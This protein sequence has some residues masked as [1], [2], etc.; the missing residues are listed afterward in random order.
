MIKFNVTKT[1]RE[2]ISN[3]SS[4]WSERNHRNQ[5]SKRT[6]FDPLLP[7]MNTIVRA[8]PDTIFW[9]KSI[10]PMGSS[11]LI[12]T[13]RDSPL[14]R[15]LVSQFWFQM[16]TF[17]T[18]TRWKGWGLRSLPSP[19][20]FQLSC[21]YLIF[22]GKSRIWRISGCAAS[23]NRVD[24]ANP[25]SIPVP[26]PRTKFVKDLRKEEEEVGFHNIYFLKFPIMFRSNLLFN[27]M[28]L[29]PK[30]CKMASAQFIRSKKPELLA[31]N[32]YFL[33]ILCRF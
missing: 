22:A 33:F 31:V 27:Q 8:L 21:K 16:I 29:Q 23:M 30:Q 5:L 11:N 1:F 2:E 6:R 13:F 3:W 32:F 18:K 20:T 19:I 15:I 26:K 7:Y 25:D 28:I 24:N 12:M 17:W 9:P 4:F 10:S 14:W